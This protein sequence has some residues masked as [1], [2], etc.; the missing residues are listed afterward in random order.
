MDK[1]IRWLARR[2]N[3]FVPVLVDPAKIPLLTDAEFQ[4]CQPYMDQ[5]RDAQFSGALLPV[6]PPAFWKLVAQEGRLTP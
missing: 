5:Y 3:A 2:Q 6:T 4:S 1:Y